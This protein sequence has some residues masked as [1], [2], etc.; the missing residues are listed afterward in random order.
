MKLFLVLILVLNATPAF[1]RPEY[2][3]KTKQNCTACHVNPWGGGPKTVYGKFYGSKDYK[4]LETSTTDLFSA[5]MR[6]I[7]YYPSGPSKTT[8]G[9]ALMEVAPS[10][11][12][13][14]TKSD[15]DSDFRAVATYNF[16]PLQS[17]AREAYIRWQPNSQDDHALMSHVMFGRFNSPF[18]LLTDEHRTYTRLQT[19]MTLNNYEMGVAFSGNILDSLHYDLAFCNDF[20]NGGGAFTNGDISYGEVLNLRWNPS[21]LPFFLGASQN[22]QHSLIFAQPYAL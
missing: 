21:S 8:N 3:L 14:L 9:I 12:V 17:G 11:N 18:G 4:P 15:A 16:S 6:A 20:Q 1:A 7:A 10:A 2:A 19:N 13:P 22:Y 5:D